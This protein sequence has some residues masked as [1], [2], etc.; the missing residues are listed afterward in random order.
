MITLLLPVALSLSS[1]PLRAPP[2]TRTIVVET[3]IFSP[4]P[5][6]GMK[7]RQKITV[8]T[9]SC[10]AKSD[11]ETGTTSLAGFQLESVR[12]QFK[13]RDVKC[14]NG[15]ITLGLSGETASGVYFMPNINYD[16]TITLAS[17]NHIKGCHDGYPGYTVSVDGN[18]IYSF[19]HKPIELIKLLGTC[20]IKVDR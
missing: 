2:Q 14:L 13:V 10:S 3:R 19:R 17:E 18:E 16:F 4:D 8:N 9:A 5:Q 1:E 15:K 12:N 20:D 11:F 7:S 6:A